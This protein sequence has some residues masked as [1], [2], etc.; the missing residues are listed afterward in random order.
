VPAS[1][2]KNRVLELAAAHPGLKWLVIHGSTFNTID[3]TGADTVETL[4]GELARQ[5]IRLGLA[6]LSNVDRA[7]R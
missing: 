1:Y 7:R 4:A 6:G 5:N 3:S 2:L